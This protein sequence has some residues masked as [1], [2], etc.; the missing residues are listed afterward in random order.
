MGR[1]ANN[2][3]SE[4][5]EPDRKLVKLALSSLIFGVV[6]FFPSL[7]ILDSMIH[8]G[9][10]GDFQGGGMVFMLCLWGM[11]P[12]GLAGVITGIVAFF[13]IAIKKKGS[14]ILLIPAIIGIILGLPGTLTLFFTLFKFKP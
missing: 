11:A 1:T 8:P 3:N 2:L 6:S 14:K 7:M 5:A 13:N 12:V 9:S 4:S 10:G